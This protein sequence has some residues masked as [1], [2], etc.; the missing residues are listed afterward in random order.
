MGLRRPKRKENS[1]RASSEFASGRPLSTQHS[2][3]STIFAGCDR[4]KS[5][6]TVKQG[7][8]NRFLRKF[9]EAFAYLLP[10]AATKNAT[11]F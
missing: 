5:Q 4:F 3:L 10:R 9:N 2:V 8:S 7:G 6:F 1:E 11:H